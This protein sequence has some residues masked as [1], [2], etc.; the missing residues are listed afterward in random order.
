MM[1]TT[2]VKKAPVK[3]PKRAI[4]IANRNKDQEINLLT[5]DWARINRELGAEE[6]E[7]PQGGG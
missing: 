2:E 3:S 7:F 6:D 4:A 5:T 1:K